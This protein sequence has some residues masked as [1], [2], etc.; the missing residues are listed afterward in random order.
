MTN[1]KKLAILALIAMVLTMLPVQL[2]AATADD[3]RLFGANRVETALAVADAGWDTA[4][5]VVLAPADQPN[6]VD[7]LAAAPLA[8]QA[9]APILLTPKNSLDPTVKAKI[10][11]L[12]ATKVY[13]I[14]AISD[15]VKDQVAAISGVT[16]EVLKGADRWATAKAINAKLTNVAGTFV[17]GY[18]ALAD[19]LSVSSFA[20]ANNYAI[21]LADA[22]GKIPAGQSALGSKTYLVGGPTLVADI[23]GATRLAGDNRYLTNEEVIKTLSYEYSKVYVANGMDSHL[24]D[25]LV[26][27]PLAAKT[28]APIVLTD[29]N[30]VEAAD[31]VNAKINSSTKAIAL[32]GTGVVSDAMKAAISLTATP[33]NFVVE[34]IAPVSLDAI[35]V[36]FNQVVDE[37]TA[38][39][40]T[41][42]KIDG[43]DLPAGSKAVLQS[44]GKT[45]LLFVETS[46]AA[47]TS[48]FS[49]NQVITV[50]VKGNVVY[51]EAKNLSSS[52]L[53]KSLTMKDIDVPVI[54]KV[55]VFGNKKITVKFSEPVKIP[56]QADANSWTL[57]G[58]SLSSLGLSDV[59]TP[60]ATTGPNT[61]SDT[62]NL[63]FSAPLAAGTYTLLVKDGTVGGQLSD[64]ANFAF[65][66]SSK[67]ITVES[68]TTEPK[69]ESVEIVNNTIYVTFDRA[70]YS[71]AN[72]A[73]NSTDSNSALNHDNYFLNDGGNASITAASFKSGS[74]SKVVK[75]TAATGSIKSG[76]NVLEIDKDIKDAW[77]N[78]L[79]SGN[80][81][82]R[83]SFEYAADT[84]KPTVISVAAVSDTKVRIHF[85]EKVDY[86]F[87]ET[88]ANYTIKN[89]DGVQVLGST[90]G[91]TAQTVPTGTNSDTVELIMPNGAYL[92][93]SDYSITIKNLRDTALVQ[94][95]MDSYSTTFNGIDDI[96]PILS[97]VIVHST[98]TSK[99]VAFFN[100][101]LDSSTVI[102]ANFG[103]TDG[104]GKAQNL[105]SGTTVSLDG[106]GK[107]VTIDFPAAYTVQTAGGG[108]NDK[109]EVNAIRV[110]N[111]KDKAGNLLQGV[112][113]TVAVAAPSNNVRPAFVANSFNLF[114]EGTDIRA[115]FTLNQEVST[116][117]TG[118]FAIGTT[119]G[120]FA[121]GTVADTGYTVGKKVVLKYTTAASIK[122]IRALGVNAYIHSDAQNNIS[123]NNV[124]GVTV[125]AFNAA[126][127]Q[128]YDDQVKPRIDTDTA[129]D[130][131]S[132]DGIAIPANHAV[133]AITFTEDIDAS[134]VGLYS[135]DFIFS[136][137]GRGLTVEN[138]VVSGKVVKFDVGLSAGLAGAASVK[139]VADKIDIRDNK[140]SGAE[141]YN[142]YVPSA[143]DKDGRS[144]V[145]FH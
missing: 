59:T 89:A 55:T 72:S 126:G 122:A 65:L 31:T 2:F 16:V 109:Y 27:A 48:P 108:S 140:D 105:P 135:D 28:K 56:T 30:T 131:T 99:A 144:S 87:A 129:I 128:V 98:D 29:N 17:V 24:V 83:K 5:T 41:N 121:G 71:N 116:L 53:S 74:G 66:E 54:S 60:D 145:A 133:I 118:D 61:I 57:N 32:G 23:S 15:S 44:D 3:T 33:A 125:L 62:V 49:Q 79:S 50:E 91:G 112:A 132:G 6:L 46:G 39:I 35:K 86:N 34:E 106:T 68:I 70:M 123:T 85:S 11:S 139:A 137:S 58:A 64:I 141:N 136:N 26:A 77:G 130:F 102:A 14:G 76:V 97:E 142:V 113:M 7:A 90:A 134:I 124:A 19:A 114:D 9:N 22:Q 63:Y 94:N 82:I 110:S 45:V 81:N 20:A 12:G 13:V 8:G 38:E 73:N 115:E 21:I 1:T 95:I 42:Y 93:G 111:V 4:D 84:T 37:D 80:D 127:Y 78:K 67:Q 119:G 36:V 107:I 101:G 43:S 100:E 18:A 104:E 117:D 40:V 92:R 138:V 10:S 143:T 120:G 88:I 103:Y 47:G 96:G 69:V 75:L 25:S 51:N 52:G